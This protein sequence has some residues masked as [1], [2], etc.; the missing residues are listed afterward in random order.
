MVE[1]NED[2]HNVKFDIYNVYSFPENRNVMFKFHSRLVGIAGQLAGQT[3][4]ITYS[5]FFQVSQKCL[6]KIIK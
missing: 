2:Y 5:H 4:I 1:I 6:K 3:V